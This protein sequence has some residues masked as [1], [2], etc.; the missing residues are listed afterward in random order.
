MFRHLGEFRFQRSLVQA[1]GFYLV[2]FFAGII[3]SGMLGAI[4]GLVSGANGFDDGM[5]VG[6][7]VGTVFATIFSG[8]LSFL[9]LRAK[10]QFRNVLYLLVGLLSIGA[11]WLGGLLFGLIFVA[12]LTTR[13]ADPAI[14][15][16][17]RPVEGL[18]AH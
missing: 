11:G 8:L 13:A 12:F 9:I 15:A 6:L 4:A 14:D 10:G 7:T 18:A 5:Q 1:I 17:A 3:V 16:T 2:Y